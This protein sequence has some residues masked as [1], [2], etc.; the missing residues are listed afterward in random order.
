MNILPIKENDGIEQEGDNLRSELLKLKLID[1]KGDLVSQIIPH[2]FRDI[3][4]CFNEEDDRK[5]IR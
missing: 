1:D 5:L 4:S 2:R 3:G